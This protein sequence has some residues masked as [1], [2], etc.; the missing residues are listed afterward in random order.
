MFEQLSRDLK[1]KSFHRHIGRVTRYVGLIVEATGL[2]VFVGEICHIIPDRAE[3]EIEAE[4]VGINDSKVLL[5]PYGHVRGITAGSKVIGTERSA[6]VPVGANCLGRVLD[7]FAKPIDG[8]GSIKHETNYPIHREASNPLSRE[9]IEVRVDSGVAAI[10]SFLTLGKGQRIG[11]L[12][13]SGVG[14]STLLGMLAKN[15]STQVNVIALI[16]ERGREVQD[17]IEDVL[18][19]SGMK[20][21]VVIVATADQPPLVRKH[22]VYTALAMAEFFCHGGKDVLFLM[23]SVTRFAMAQREI[24]LAAGEPPTVKGY[25]PSVFTALPAILERTGNF[26][27]KGSITGIFSVLVDGDDLNEP[28]TDAV[29]SILDGHIVLS[30]ELANEGHYPPIDLLKSISRLFD[31]L[32][33]KSDQ[34][35]LNVARKVLAAK[36]KLDELMELGVYQVGNDKKDDK[37]YTAGSKILTLMQQDSAVV[38]NSDNIFAQIKRVVQ[39]Y[40]K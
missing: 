20:Q 39:E 21:S 25:T 19:S 7:A 18:G 8:K 6:C 10:D 28:I 5:M 26:D 12:A 32:N 27:K 40:E 9:R 24:G 11:V 14:K 17:F 3:S 29:R 22:A 33:S 37:V 15:I 23:D 16:G 1:Q 4:V 31:K 2:N 30:R 38:S 36:E 34:A 35:I 13:G